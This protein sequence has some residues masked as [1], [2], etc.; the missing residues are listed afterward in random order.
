M[1]P[2]RPAG[3]LLSQ[4]G[5]ALW[6]TARRCRPRASRERT[7]NP[8]H[9]VIVRDRRGEAT[10]LLQG[11]A[12]ALVEKACAAADARGARKALQL[13][14]RDAQAGGITSVQDLGAAPGD[15]DLVRRRARRRARCRCA[16]TPRCRRHGRR[17]RISTPIAKR[18]PDDPLLKTGTR[19]DRARRLRR[20]ADGGDARAVR[21]R[22][23]R[24]RRPAH[25]GRGLSQAGG[26]ARRARLADRDR[27]HGDRAVA[28]ALDA[29]GAVAKNAQAA[30]RRA[31]R[32]E[33]L[34]A[35]DAED[36]PRFGALGVIASMQPLHATLAGL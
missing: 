25:A 11:A 23:Q 24:R 31:H 10:G 15:L 19:D 36:C 3:Q 33:R 27:R 30:A 1:P 18:Y 8:K 28:P 14:I 29:Y 34:S 9:G 5:Q 16:S 20:I 17:R 12:M 7:P 22:R 6:S 32:I 13:A 21:A 2:P 35:I 4:D 26:D